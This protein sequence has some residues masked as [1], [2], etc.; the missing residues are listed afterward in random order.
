LI[1]VKWFAWIGLA[2]AANGAFGEDPGFGVPLKCEIGKTCVVQNYVDRDSGR[3][4]HDYRCGFLTYDGHKGTDIRVIDAAALRRG[5]SVVAAADGRVRAV[6]DGMPDVSVRAL[7]K[8]VVAGR[9]AGNSVAIEHGGGWE[10]QYAHMR[11]HSVVVRP[12]DTVRR[13]QV[14]G[15][16][17]MSGETEF[18]HLHFEVR[19]DRQTVDPFV[20]PDGGE[21][22]RAG[23]HPLWTPEALAAL[24][25]TATGVLGAGI[26]G[27]QPVLGDWGIVGE[28]ALALGRASRAAI[29]WV[30]IYGAQ[31]DDVERLRLVAPDGRVLAERSTRI[32]GERAQ[33]LAYAGARRE[34]AG[35]PAGVYRGE[36]AL[37]RR[38]ERTIA[39]TREIRLGR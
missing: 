26:S 33:S 34:T 38:G 15:V 28:G 17:G 7:K 6:R 23:A 27:A 21:P 24:A 14:I 35:W 3:D 31:T 19:R 39:L 1:F 20:G 37:Y 22:C 10:T 18:P 16:V 13:G 32:P 9:E 5:V 25:Y 4:A 30:Q 2:I 12:G 11:R 8:G 29:F 36:Y